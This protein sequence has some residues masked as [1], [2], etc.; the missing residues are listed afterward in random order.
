MFFR[1]L[2]TAILACALSTSVYAQSVYPGDPDYRVDAV[3]PLLLSDAGAVVRVHEVEFDVSSTNRAAQ[4]VRRVVTIFDA[5]GRDAGT[6]VVHYDGFR[7]LKRIDAS[8]LDASGKVVRKLRKREF[9]DYSAISGFSLYDD[10]RVRVAE[11]QHDAYPYTVVVEYEIDHR[12][13]IGWPRWYPLDS[14]A[15]VEWARFAISAPGDMAVR[16][17]LSG[18]V[19]EPSVSEGSTH[20]SY[21]WVARD[22]VYQ[23]PEPLGPPAWRQYPSVMAAPDRFEIAGHAGRMD[24]WRDF[25]LW[26]HRLSEGRAE[27][28]QSVADVVDQIQADATSQR[29][30]VRKLY[31]FMQDNTRYV[32]VQLGIGGWQP[33]DVDYVVDRGYGDCK[34]LT[35]YMY[36]LLRYAEIPSHP[37]LIRSER[38][39]DRLV[40]E[41]PD[42]QFNHAILMVP[43]E[44]EGDTLWLETTDPTAPFGHI[45]ASNENRWALA[46]G[47]DGGELVRTPKSPPQANRQY[48][49]GKVEMDV[50]GA[51]KVNLATV[52]TGNQQDRIRPLA[53]ASHRDR[54]DWIH[55]ALNISDYRVLN[56]DFAGIGIRAPE[57]GLAVELDVPRFATRAGERFFFQPN[58]MERRRSVPVSVEERKQEVFASAYG[59]VDMDSLHFVLPTGYQIEAVPRDVILEEDF[60]RY[61]MRITPTEDQGLTFFRRLEIRDSILPPDAY[62]VYRTFIDGIV[63]ADRSQIVLVKQ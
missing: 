4:R 52:Y 10:S 49:T 3:D 61:E 34:A 62:D 29:D 40:P 31:E 19:T 60:G 55:H 7:R 36:A 44:E 15:S 35:N 16:Y 25:G 24:T 41:F 18:D 14:D 42:N 26:Y 43:M 11:L 27:L 8:I 59:Y 2:L 9:K 39:P 1:F 57:V 20:R 54:D 17:H 23:K 38:Y 45:G 33:F 30:L 48:R 21:E 46:V 58:V 51:A 56:A 47:P 50:L 13:F 12:G 37:T 63:R 6:A 28:P 53:R 32:S 22:I 5:G